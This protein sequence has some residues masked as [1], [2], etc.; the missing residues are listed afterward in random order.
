M[1]DQYRDL[2]PEA[3]TPGTPL[4][5]HD[6]ERVPD[7]EDPERDDAPD[8]AGDD[9]FEAGDDDEGGDDGPRQRRS[10]RDDDDDDPAELKRLLAE[11]RTLRAEREESLRQVEQREQQQRSAAYWNEREQRV[12]WAFAQ[13]WEQAREEA[14]Q[15][16]NPGAFWEERTAQIMGEYVQARTQLSNDRER[17]LWQ[18]AAQQSVPA[19]T[20]QLAEQHGLSDEE[21]RRL[22]TV[23]PNQMQ[24]EAQRIVAS[25]GEADQLKARVAE[26]ERLLTGKQVRGQTPG[27]GS[28]TARPRRVRPGS[29]AHLAQL[30]YGDRE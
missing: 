10:R 11:E 17:A 1:D 13:R 12:N 18:F 20:K 30:L 5:G 9:G 15:S 14:E 28:G 3:L 16:L 29:R 7:D 4:A 6:D 22:A 23:P 2:P 21:A 24:R 8:D 19:F 25:R 26:L 27:P